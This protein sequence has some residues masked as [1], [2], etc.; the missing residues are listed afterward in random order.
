MIYLDHSATTPLCNK[1]REAICE[2]MDNV[3]GNPSSIH[4]PGRKA[5]QSMDHSRKRLAGC[6]DVDPE[7]VIFTASGSEANNLALKGFLLN[8]QAIPSHVIV[9]SIEHP[10]TLD[11]LRSMARINPRLNLTEVDSEPDGRISAQ[12]VARAITPDTC[13]ISVMHANNETGVI[14]PVEEISEIARNHR[15]RFHTDAIQSFGRIPVNCPRIGCDFLS[16][17]AHKF[18]GPKG[19]GALIISGDADLH[20][21]IHG[22]HQEFMLRAGTENIVGAAGMAAAAE[23]AV[24]RLESGQSKLTELENRFRNTLKDHGL[25][26]Q[27]NGSDAEKVSGVINLAVRG[28]SRDDLVVG[29]DLAS[30][31][32]SAGAAC[33]SGV[34]E[35]SHVLTSMHLT[36]W[37]I[38]G[39]IRISFGRGNTLEEAIEAA[40]QLIRLCTSLAD[41]IMNKESS[42]R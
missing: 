33:S 7:S 17:S 2:V 39:G 24:N 35:R 40:K 15:I 12:A 19:M 16:L 1:A 6:L 30:I 14:Q 21:L 8:R 31:A 9:S 20:P 34:I 25:L 37:Q 42:V 36:D 41:G 22:G 29:L 32:I 11:S 27:V 23:D 28:V 38:E 4:A 3:Y 13:L 26:F 10:S 18:Y 5:R